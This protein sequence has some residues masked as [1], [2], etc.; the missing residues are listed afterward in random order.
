MKWMFE[1]IA[2]CSAIAMPLCLIFGII[3]QSINN[4]AIRSGN[5]IYRCFSAASTVQFAVPLILGVL[6]LAGI[7]VFQKPELADP[8]QPKIICRE[9]FTLTANGDCLQMPP[10]SLRSAAPAVGSQAITAPIT[11]PMSEPERKPQTTITGEFGHVPTRWSASKPPP[12]LASQYSFPQPNAI[13][14]ERSIVNGHYD[15]DNVGN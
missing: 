15:L 5:V 4:R 6:S 3:D 7:S 12:A 10:D 1:I 8:H 9:G 14:Q 13:V 11:S 2:G